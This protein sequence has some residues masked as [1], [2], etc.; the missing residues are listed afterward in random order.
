MIEKRH[1]L[2]SSCRFNI[3]KCL[4]VGVASL[5]H[6]VSATL[7]SGRPTAFLV[8]MQDKAGLLLLN[9]LLPKTE[10]LNVTVVHKSQLRLLFLSIIIEGERMESPVFD[11]LHYAYISSPERKEYR[12]IRDMLLVTE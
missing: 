6:E 3:L 7:Q 9:C 5:L 11:R 12:L 2:T 10:R 1:G 4:T 8:Q